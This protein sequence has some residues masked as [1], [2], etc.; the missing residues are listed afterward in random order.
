M[1]A[2]FI[3]KNRERLVE[4]LHPIM[5]GQ[6]EEADSFF[7]EEREMKYYI[8][9]EICEYN[10]EAIKDFNDA[11]YN[12]DTAVRVY[13]YIDFGTSQGVHMMMVFVREGENTY[14]II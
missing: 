11:G 5:E 9:D 13:A 12:I 2:I 3:D 1:Q 10:H 14:V 6:F 4:V 8:I 7:D